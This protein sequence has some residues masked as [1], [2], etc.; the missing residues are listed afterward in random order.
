MSKDKNLIGYSDEIRSLIRE[1][2]DER[3]EKALMKR[4]ER[5]KYELDIFDPEWYIDRMV[6]AARER[7]E[8]CFGPGDEIARTK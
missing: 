7:G 1:I 5:L 3:E 8:T 4:I 6:K 2:E